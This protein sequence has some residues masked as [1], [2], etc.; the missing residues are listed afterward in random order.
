VK[1]SSLASHPDALVCPLCEVGRLRSASRNSSRCE[2]CGAPFGE[3]LLGLLNQIVGLPDA[4]GRHACECGHP[5]MRLLPDGTYH[6]PACGSEIAPLGAPPAAWKL[7]GR[8]KAY[9]AGWLDGRF[10]EP[11]PFTTNPELLRWQSPH[12]RLEYYR[13][14]RE[15]RDL[16]RSRP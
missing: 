13:G 3:A 4:T 11:R 10:G 7:D 9:W 6:C 12:D 5:E 2:S 8:G 1:S 15:G 14:H 16:R